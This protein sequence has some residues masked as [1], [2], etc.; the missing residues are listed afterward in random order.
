MSRTLDRYLYAIHALKET[1][2]CVRAID[3][4]HYLGLSKPS[5]SIAIRQ[6]RDKGLIEVEPDGNL[7]FTDTGTERSNQ[8]QTRVCFFQQLLICAGIDPALALQ[9]AISFSW[10]MSDASFEAFRHLHAGLI[11]QQAAGSVTH[12]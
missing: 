3:V 2:L 9:D 7:L 1:Y 6:M 8:L 12:S 4:A 10:E 11:P 5:V